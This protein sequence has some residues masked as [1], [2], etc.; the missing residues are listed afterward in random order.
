MQN[1]MIFLKVYNLNHLV[2]N[3]NIAKLLN[4]DFT[5]FWKC[6]TLGQKSAFSNNE[7]K[8]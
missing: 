5:N 1:E 4:A 8:S 7:E 6:P 2:N 3:K